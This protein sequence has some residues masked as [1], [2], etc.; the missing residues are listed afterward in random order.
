M[1]QKYLFL[2]SAAAFLV[3][4]VVFAIEAATTGSEVAALER[5]E[6][7]LREENKGLSETITQSASLSSLQD[8]AVEFNFAKPEIIV[9]LGSEETIAKVP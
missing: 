3:G 7:L 9:Y 5:Q 6:A 2:I 8:K 4:T 1:K